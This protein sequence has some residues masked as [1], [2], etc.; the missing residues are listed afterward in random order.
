MEVTFS[1]RRKEIVE[2]VPMVSEVQE[3][4]PALFYEA[5]I[6]EEFLRIT[7]K[8]LIDNFGAA[9]NQHTPRLLKLYRARRTAFPPEMDQLLNRLDE[10]TS[11][12]TV[13]RHTAALKGLPLY[14]HDSHEK[15]FRNCLA[16]DPEEEQMKG[17]IV[18][19][20]TVLEDDDSSAPATVINVAVVVEEDIVLQDL[21]DLPT[22]FAY[23]FG[24]IYAL[25]LQYPKELRYTFETIQKVF[26]ELGTDLSARVRS[27]KNKLL[28]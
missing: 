17:L 18:G 6:R 14:L 2:L 24:L 8:D 9:I 12:I 3:R 27:F 28:Q 4:W 15:L 1:L 19:I 20:L 21:P 5:E 23:L 13:H 22:T 16:T 11:D 10:E 25:N 7:N 26:M